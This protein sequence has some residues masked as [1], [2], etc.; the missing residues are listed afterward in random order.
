MTDWGRSMMRFWYSRQAAN[1][2]IRLRHY[3]FACAWHP[4]FGGRG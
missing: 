3:F 1:G 4:V 2:N